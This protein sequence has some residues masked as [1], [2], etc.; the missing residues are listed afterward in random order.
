MDGATRHYVK[1]LEHALRLCDSTTRQRAVQ[2]LTDCMNAQIIDWQQYA[3]RFR[4]VLNVPH[5][6][7]DRLPDIVAERLRHR[8][9]EG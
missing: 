3:N 1:E 2:I 6:P 9:K 5:M 7:A 4:V 8:T